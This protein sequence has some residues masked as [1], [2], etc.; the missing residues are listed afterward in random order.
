MYWRYGIFACFSAGALAVFVGASN[1]LGEFRTG[2]MAA[3]LGA[4]PA[5]LAGGLASAG[6][7]ETPVVG[8]GAPA[9][10]A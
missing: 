8:R 9:Y 1:E 2:V 4:V 7:R 3:W 10:C 6:G 5:A